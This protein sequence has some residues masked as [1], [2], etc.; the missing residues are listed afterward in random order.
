VEVIERRLKSKREDGRNKV[1]DGK[2]DGLLDDRGLNLP[3]KSKEIALDEREEKKVSNKSPF[4]LLSPHLPY[5]LSHLLLIIEHS[6]SVVLIGNA[7]NSLLI[8]TYVFFNESEQR[9][10]NDK[11]KDKIVDKEGRVVD[12]TKVGLLYST[13]QFM[14]HVF[15][16]KL[17]DSSKGEDACVEN[18]KASD[19]DKPSTQSSATE[20][21]V[22][23]DQ[24]GLFG[25][26][27]NMMLF[28]TN[29]LPQDPGVVEALK[30][31]IAENVGIKSFTYNLLRGA[32]AGCEREFKRLVG[33]NT[34]QRR[35]I[36][37]SFELLLSM[38]QC[39]EMS[40]HHLPPSFYFPL[41]FPATLSNP[42]S[43][44]SE[45]EHLYH[46]FSLFASPSYSVLSSPSPHSSLTSN[47]ASLSSSASLPSTLSSFFLTTLPLPRTVPANLVHSA[48]GMVVRFL[49]TVVENHGRTLD[50]GW[51]YIFL[52]ITLLAKCG[53]SRG[54][55][56]AY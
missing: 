23:S 48:T 15:Y 18:N 21:R 39:S 1:D 45:Y 19:T 26:V 24:L 54:Y 46:L 4:I 32:E 33:D 13:N 17:D 50:A 2:E 28:M 41:L 56:G 52:I 25:A 30:D 47:P 5:F 38:K 34:P 43:F 36:V 8:L 3:K 22:V 16:R 40:T 14:D 35:I 27:V 37:P 44:R 12:D 53:I 29:R 7:V 9:K 10:I 20:E 31:E 11:P 51:K 42:D 49:T 55:D 6:R